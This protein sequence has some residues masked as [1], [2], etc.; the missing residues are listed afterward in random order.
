V[1]DLRGFIEDYPRLLGSLGTEMASFRPRESVIDIPA[2]GGFSFI[3]HLARLVPQH[4]AAKEVS[5]SITAVEYYHVTKEGN[6]VKFLATG[7]IAPHSDL[8][9]RYRAIASY[10]N[11]LFR[12]GLILALL[13][14]KPWFRPFGKLFAQWPHTFFVPCDDSPKFSWFWADARK[15]LKEVIADMPNDPNPSPPDPNDKLAEL[16]YRM[17]RTYL[18]LKAKDK[19]NVNLE[20][21][22]A[23]DKIQWDK[24]PRAYDDAKHQI[25]ESLFME[26]RS[27]HD[28]A[29]VDQFVARLGAVK[30]FLS[31]D[32]Y[33]V[34]CKALATDRESIKTL[35]LLALSANS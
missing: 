7:R 18:L 22:K 3:E 28:Q 13:D 16:I 33:I 25:A 14:E 30:Q 15:K 6:N 35:T 32:D 9:E 10:S 26:Y 1:A 34:I 2:E 5:L 29:F 31:E 24:V 20:Q 12:R 8:A 4:I 27:R 11:P 21:F 23:G 19:S 17:V